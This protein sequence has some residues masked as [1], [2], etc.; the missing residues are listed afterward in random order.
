MTAR[1]CIHCG[2]PLAVSGRAHA[3]FCGAGCRL[4]SHRGKHARVTVSPARPCAKS[5]APYV[6]IVPDAQWPGMWRLK[7][8]DETLSDMVN[9]TRAKDA[10]AA[11]LDR[12]ARAKL[13]EEARP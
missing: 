2:A 7:R 3:K 11:A 6:R 10:L 12:Q 9:L 13:A 4:A 1:S 5:L 8:A